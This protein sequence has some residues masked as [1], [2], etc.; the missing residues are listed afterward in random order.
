MSVAPYPYANIST[1]HLFGNQSAPLVME[2]FVSFSCAV[3]KR[4]VNVTEKA[5][6]RHP[7]E[8][9]FRLRH[10]PLPQTPNAYLAAQAFECA[11]DQ[12]KEWEIAPKLYADPSKFDRD[13]LIATAESAG[14]EKG[15]FIWCLDSGAKKKVVDD[16]L[17]VVAE[18]KMRGTPYFIIGN[19]T[20]PNMGFEE[21]FLA[22]VYRAVKEQI[23][24]NR[25]K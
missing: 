8:L 1:Q 5:L 21:D 10:F 16:D 11:A 18:H 3:C 6:R 25:S 17:A 23:P 7:T 13:S 9:A 22:Q 14:V 19:A 4:S 2:E 20:I 12:G 15:M 24:D